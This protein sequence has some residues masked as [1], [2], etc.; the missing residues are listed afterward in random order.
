[1]TKS[2]GAQRMSNDAWLFIA[3]LLLLIGTFILYPVVMNIYFS[4][5]NWKGFGKVSFIG[6]ANYA[7]MF[8]D[9]K[10]WISISNTALLL[11]YIPISTVIT[12]AVA[13][14]LREGLRGWAVFRALLYIPNLLGV[15]IIGTVFNLFLRDSGPI[16]MLISL[17]GGPA[18]PF[19]THPTLALLSVGFISIVWAPIGF[20]VIY[21]LAAMSNIDASQYEAARI[22]GSGPLRTFWF[23]TI[24]SVRFA[25]EFW[26]VMSFINV[27]ARMFGFIYVFSQGGPGYATFTLEYGIYEIGMIKF[28]PGYS[29]AWATVLFVLCAFISLAQIRLMKRSES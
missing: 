3:P 10:F 1:M 11:I 29:S 19:L 14:I 12:L 7:K 16:N 25:I 6:L 5:T 4:F 28:N 8:A 26:V 9:E 23:I 20:G 22:D 15:V 27:F 17:A 18:I 2:L 24:P 13:A 21:F